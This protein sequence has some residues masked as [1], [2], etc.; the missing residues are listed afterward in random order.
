MTFP[1]WRYPNLDKFIGIRIT[2]L[3]YPAVGKVSFLRREDA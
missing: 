3:S 2:E 1:L